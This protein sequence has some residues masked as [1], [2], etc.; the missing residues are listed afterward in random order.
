MC[1]VLSYAY[2]LYEQGLIW[3]DADMVDYF[4]SNMVDYFPS[5]TVN[6][7]PSDLLDYLP[8]R[9]C[10]LPPTPDWEAEFYVNQASRYRTEFI[11][12]SKI[13]KG[14]FGSVYKV[15]CWIIF[16]WVQVENIEKPENCHCLTFFLCIFYSLLKQFFLSQK[17]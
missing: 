11:E 13:G 12:L 2:M 17:T 6:Y 7:L 3:S 1:I 15:T 4:P 16:A 8:S 9:D 5:D 14:G 10:S